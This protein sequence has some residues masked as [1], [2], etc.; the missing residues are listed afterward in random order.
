MDLGGPRGRMLTY[1][2]VVSAAVTRWLVF[3]IALESLPL[4]DR[5]RRSFRD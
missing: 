2:I 3:G 1:W 5:A 4:G